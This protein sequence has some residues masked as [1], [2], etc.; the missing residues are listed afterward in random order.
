MPIVTLTKCRL[1]PLRHPHHSEAPCCSYGRLREAPDQFRQAA[2]QRYI[3]NEKVQ[4]KEFF[5]TLESN[6]L[7][8]AQRL[9]VIAHE[10][11]VLTIAGAGSGK[12]SVIVAKAGYLLKKDLCKPEQLL[13]L[14]YNKSAA[15]ELSQ[16]IKERVGIEVRATTFHALGLG[17]LG[18]V[19]GLKPSLTRFAEAGELKTLI[20]ELILDLIRNP[21]TVKLVRAYFQSFFAPYKSDTEFAT[22]GDYYDYIRDN[23]L[24]TLKGERVKSYE[25]IEIANFLCLNGIAYEYERK[26]EHPV[27]DAAHRQYQPDFYLTDHG[28]YIEHFGIGRDGATAPHVDRASYAA[29]MAWKRQTHLQHGTTLIETYSYEK[30]DGTLL[31]GLTAKLEQRGIQLRPITA[32]ELG[33]ILAKSEYLDPFSE[34]VATFL[35]HFKGGGHSIKGIRA[36]AQ[37]RQRPD[38]RLD[39]FLNV[40]AS[41]LDRYEQRL[42]QDQ[43]IDFND[44]IIR[45]AEHAESGR[46]RS[47]YTHILV[48]EFQDISSGRARFVKALV[49]Q[50]PNH[51]LFCVGDDWQAIY[52]F[53]GSDIGLMRNFEEHFGWAERV[54]LDRTFRFNNRL[55]AVATRFILCNPSQIKKTIRAQATVAGPRV[56]IHRPERKQGDVV[57]QILKDLVKEKDA[58]RE[59]LFLG[60]YRFLE[61]GL[62][63]SAMRQIYP[64]IQMRFQ[65]V[66]RAKGQQADYVIVLGMQAGKYG[67]PSE[68]ADDPLLGV[69]LSEPEGFAHA[70]E[71]RLF[72]VAITR[73]RHAVHLIADYTRPS[74]FLNEI[75]RY[76]EV[77][78]IGKAT[79]EPAHCPVCKTGILQ[80]QSGS[81]GAFYGCSHYPLCTYTANPCS[82]CQTGLLVLQDGARRYVCN[83]TNCRHTERICP[84]CETG[85][86]VERKGRN[87]PFLGCANFSKTGCRY[88]E[89]IDIAQDV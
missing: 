6:P 88:T 10:H 85:R 36:R 21:A 52:R 75:M 2:N 28:I 33:A 61:D 44:M 11:N 46:Y 67:F 65:T 38:S 18:E 40:F 8:E 14:A 89:N 55:E 50:E 19:D 37:Q 25:E 45:A 79:S 49:K 59:I 87:G 34:L 41:I 39:A 57:L 15:D 35:G 76:D 71:R 81:K 60:R 31:S 58:P 17:I 53:A 5:D 51:R 42:K 22:L 48:D 80:L 54:A 66:H 13:L 16:R 32:E 30:R 73:A 20:R 4:F 7:T 24:L 43:G 26:Y 47:P 1:K 84:R 72:Y 77:R 69:V 62:A 74:V 68:V 56:F 64:G 82:R 70:E 29:G 12:T 9:A 23:N 83:N 78:V 86:L 3:E 27:A 63:W